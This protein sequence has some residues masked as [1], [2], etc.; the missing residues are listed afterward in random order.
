MKK[1][2]P[3][4]IIIPHGGYDICEELI[5]HA[6]ISDFD[7]FFQADTCTNDLFDFNEWAIA[8]I[9]TNISRFF[10]DLDRSY[11]DISKSSPD[12][13]LKNTTL[14]GKKVF[15]TNVYPN[16][17]AISNILKRY[18]FPFHESIEKI[19][20]SGEI[21]LVIEGHTTMP[22]G[23]KV[24]FDKGKPRPLVQIQNHYEKGDKITKTCDDEIA[25][26]LLEDLYNSLSGEEHTIAD[27]LTLDKAPPRSLILKKY[28]K[29]NIPI[30]RLSI[31]KSLF[32]N[33]TYFNYD[34][35][36]VDELRIKELSEKI[37]GTIIK[38]YKKSF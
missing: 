38:W 34:Y 4:L 13:V 2:L 14:M 19:I 9:D 18:Y 17:I 32:L 10:I 5:D 24:S 25:L 15:D 1:K 31:S 29:F 22:V 21:K 20:K 16:E 33:D 27:T 35:L 30:L 28:S 37:G 8:T 36:S 7:L 26:T 12:G 6:V 3:I 11:G 23:P